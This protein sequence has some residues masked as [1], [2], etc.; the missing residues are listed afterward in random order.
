[1]KRVLLLLMS[2]LLLLA[3]CTKQD[4]K[5]R[6]SESADQFEHEESGIDY[7]TGIYY[8]K[9]WETECLEGSNYCVIPDKETAVKIATVIY[10][11]LP[12]GTYPAQA[13]FFDEEDEVWIVKFYSP[14]P[15]TG[16]AATDQPVHSIA[17]QKRD[18]K[19]LAIRVN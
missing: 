13:V 11:E 4:S 18:G 16:P 15:E 19:V 1:M 8:E 14:I 3:G 12:I 5:I 2:L 9:F 17:L 7:R 6:Q 10:H